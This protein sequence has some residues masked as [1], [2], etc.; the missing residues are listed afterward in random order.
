MRN[1][2][3][4]YIKEL[5]TYF[6]SPIVYVVGLGYT[7]LMGF[8]SSLA[9]KGFSD[10]SQ[11]YQYRQAQFPGADPPDIAEACLVP[12]WWTSNLMLVFFIPLLTMRLLAE[13]KRQGTFELL[14]SYPLR[15]IELV[16]GKFAACLS[17]MFVVIG[18]SLLFPM[19]LYILGS[20]PPLAFWAG[21]LGL[22][23]LVATYTA[24][25]LFWS[26]ITEN[27]IVAAV[28]TYITLLGLWL[29]R[30]FADYF[31]G[32]RAWLGKLMTELNTVSHFEDVSQGVVDTAHIAYFVLT[33]IFFIYV[34]LR[35]I[36]S[37]QWRG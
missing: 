27:Q 36:E 26:S 2:L 12:F 1:A 31:S 8:F 21:L 33:S 28:L 35:V 22:I 15:D 6:T 10:F 14:F 29:M 32:E 16:L 23:L 25:G 37:K 18:A 13:E 24:L 3:T 34:T 19:F 7:F 5:R 17:A 11:N 4:I 20:P 9:L 30:G